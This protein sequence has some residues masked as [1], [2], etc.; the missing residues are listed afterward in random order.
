MLPLRVRHIKGV[1]GTG[2]ETGS[3]CRLTEAKRYASTGI[4]QHGDGLIPQKAQSVSE[5]PRTPLAEHA[6][7]TAAHP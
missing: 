5:L 2:I 4:R 3:R 1:G 6:H 7:L